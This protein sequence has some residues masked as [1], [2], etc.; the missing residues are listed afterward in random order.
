MLSSLSERIVIS[1][2]PFLVQDMA[3][4]LLDTILAEVGALSD[5]LTVLV[6]ELTGP[7]GASLVRST[8]I[9]G[10]AGI[11]LFLEAAGRLRPDP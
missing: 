10:S 4:A 6:F 1:L 5:D 2:P 11:E 3:G 7:G 8:L 9:P